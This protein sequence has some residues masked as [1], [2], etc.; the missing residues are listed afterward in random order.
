MEKRRLFEMERQPGRA[1]VSAVG[2]PEVV[3]SAGSASVAT[4]HVYAVRQLARRVV[5]EQRAGDLPGSHD[6]HAMMLKEAVVMVF[7]CSG[8]LEGGAFTLSRG[9]ISESSPQI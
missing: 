2:C 5:V 7:G 9:V 3:D 6:W 1:P 8:V 4:P